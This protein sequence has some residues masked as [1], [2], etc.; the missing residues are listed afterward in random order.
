MKGL[1]P[2]PHLNGKKGIS[3]VFK[4]KKLTDFMVDKR[5]EIVVLVLN[6][7]IIRNRRLLVSVAWRCAT[8]DPLQGKR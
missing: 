8:Q 5:G 6:L 4:E 2:C 7:L 3:P 1:N